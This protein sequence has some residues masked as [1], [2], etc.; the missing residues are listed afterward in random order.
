M[1]KALLNCCLLLLTLRL[2]KFARRQNMKKTTGL[3][4]AL[5]LSAQILMPPMSETVLQWKCSFPLLAELLCFHLTL[6]GNSALQHCILCCAAKS[7]QNLQFSS[8][9]SW[10][11]SGSLERNLTPDS[12]MIFLPLLLSF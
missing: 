2:N 9:V 1:Q 12:S 11:T 8:H 5:K 7:T 6:L 10:H 3:S 4:S